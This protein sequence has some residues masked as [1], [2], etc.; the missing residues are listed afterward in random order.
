L[1]D[2]MVSK[3]PP[4]P[5][6]ADMGCFFKCDGRFGRIALATREIEPD[7]REMIASQDVWA[8]NWGAEALIKMKK[9]AEA[10]GSDQ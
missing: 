1:V 7:L 5:N 4:S 2:E 3:K 10:E 9:Q 8:R 6:D